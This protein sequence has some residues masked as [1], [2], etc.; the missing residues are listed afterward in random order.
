M[1]T[2]GKVEEE[3][4]QFMDLYGI[5]KNRIREDN[6]YGYEQWKAGGYIIDKDIMSM[7]PCLEDVIVWD[8]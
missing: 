3:Y 4:E 8:E 2:D 5:L 6:P 7:Y 1:F